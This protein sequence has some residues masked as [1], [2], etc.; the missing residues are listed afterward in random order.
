M[1]RWESAGSALGQ[2]WRGD[3]DRASTRSAHAC[4][5]RSWIGPLV[6]CRLERI[7][8]VAHMSPDV[9]KDLVDVGF[10][11]KWHDA[12]YGLAMARDQDRLAGFLQLAEIFEHLGLEFAFADGR[13]CNTA[14]GGI[15]NGSCAIEH[16]LVPANQSCRLLVFSLRYRCRCVE[17]RCL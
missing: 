9:R 2:C 1:V 8:M 15:T 10:V 3:P 14:K 12:G 5:G 13:H 16:S 17:S 7:A 4:R 6:Q 11:A